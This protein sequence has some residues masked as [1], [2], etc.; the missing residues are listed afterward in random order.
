MKLVRE[1]FEYSFT[2]LTRYYVVGLVASALMWYDKLLT[3]PSYSLVHRHREEWRQQRKQLTRRQD[4]GMHKV[5]IFTAAS[6]ATDELTN[7]LSSAYVAG[8]QV[9][10]SIFPSYILHPHYNQY[11]YVYCRS[12]EWARSTSIIPRKL[13]GMRN[14]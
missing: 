14:M 5:H 10:V 6:D 12:W 13:N 9:N 3:T 4:N 11:N 2:L 8:V 7:L 1:C